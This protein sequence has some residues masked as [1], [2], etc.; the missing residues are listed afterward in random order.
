MQSIGE[1]AGGRTVRAFG[2]HEEGTFE[3]AIT[4][5][6]TGFGGWRAGDRTKFDAA[7]GI[8]PATLF[9]FLET[10]QA[11][12]LKRLRKAYRDLWQSRLLQTLEKALEAHGTF[13]ILRKGLEDINL[14]GPLRLA[15]FR[16]ASGMNPETLAA[17]DANI[18][19]ATR[20]VHHSTKKPNHSLDLVLSINGIPVATAELKNPFTGQTYAS[21]VTIGIRATDQSSPLNVAHSCTSRWTPIWCS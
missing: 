8:F 6:M 21:I 12:A 2:F 3:T 18:L 17:Y 19:E 11:D 7:L 13:H 5:H 16:P 1:N 10:T 4:D 14:Q 20:Q 9:A 15:F